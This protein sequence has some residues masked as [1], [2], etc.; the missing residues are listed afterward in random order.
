MGAVRLGHVAAGEVVRVIV[1]LGEVDAGELV[2]G[3]GC[4]GLGVGASVGVGTSVGVGLG[5]AGDVVV[6]AGAG[7]D[8]VVG[9][10][11][12]GDVV[13]GAGAAGDDV[14]GAGAGCDLVGAGAL[15]NAAPPAVNPAPEPRAASRGWVVEGAAEL[16]GAGAV[17][18]A[19]V[20]AGRARVVSKSSGRPGKL[21]DKSSEARTGDEGASTPPAVIMATPRPDPEMITAVSTRKA[22]LRPGSSRR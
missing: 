11:A 3:A 8:D 19:V 7:G 1:A 22:V 5:G 14:V 9:A 20:G 17:A 21:P 4:V 16:V 12:A 6:G 13:V 18:G 15:G 2:L 10:G